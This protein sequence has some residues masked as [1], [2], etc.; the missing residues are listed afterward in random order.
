[1]TSVLKVSVP[2]RSPSCTLP[3]MLSSMKVGT[4]SF[5]SM[6]HTS[7]VKLCLCTDV[8]KDT[9]NTQ[10]HTHSLKKYSRISMWC[11][12]EHRHMNLIWTRKNTKN[13]WR[14]SNKWTA[15]LPRHLRKFPS[16][17]CYERTQFEK[18]PAESKTAVS[19]CPVVSER[20]GTERQLQIFPHHP[21]LPPGHCNYLADCEAE[22]NRA[23]FIKH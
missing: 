19:L 7:I 23:K 3:L 4:L 10:T 20:T 17:L 12:T 16:L 5:L 18:L 1:M 21:P 8:L 14:V 9:C 15:H 13:M 11:I 2:L 6:T 22:Q